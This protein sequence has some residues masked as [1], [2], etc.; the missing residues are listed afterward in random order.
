MLV[1][2]GK[3]CLTSVHL[4]Y[5]IMIHGQTHMYRTY[6]CCDIRLQETVT[7]KPTLF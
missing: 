7:G 5:Y 2:I 3:Q 6:T 4:T 1:S